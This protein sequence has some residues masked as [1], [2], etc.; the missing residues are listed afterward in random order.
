MHESIRLHGKMTH[1]RDSTRFA[2]REASLES[3]KRPPHEGEL[4]LVPHGS[5][6]HTKF[7]I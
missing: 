3:K 2:N 5:Y 6:K 1:L 4:G 7:V